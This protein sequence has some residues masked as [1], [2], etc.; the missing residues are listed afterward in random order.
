MSKTSKP[1]N[2]TVIDKATQRLTALKKYVTSAKTEIPIDGVAQKVSQVIAIYQNCLD[3]RA[4]LS[5]KRAETKAAMGERT[6]A[7]ASRR[8]ADRALKAWVINTFGASSQQAIDFGFPPPK[9]PAR[10]VETKANAVAL[11]KATRVARHTMG[12]KKRLEIKGTL[13]VSTAPA[14]P[15]NNTVQAAAPAST[16]VPPVTAAAVVAQAP[17]PQA[18][19]AP[20]LATSGA[21]APVTNGVPAPVAN[22]AS[23]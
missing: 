8:A 2:A 5:T 17:P 16:V 3:T 18:A 22:G 9:V 13:P 6:D 1:N 11:G 4:A 23:H 10:T 12:P 15:A 21:P 19:S 7:E 14:A 20:V